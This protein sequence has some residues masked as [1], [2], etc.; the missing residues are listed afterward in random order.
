[1][2]A[3]LKK[4]K[5]WFLVSFVLTAIMIIYPGVL[6]NQ[7]TSNKIFNSINDI[8]HNNVGLLLG[9]GKYLISGINPY[10][11]NRIDATIKLFMAKKIDFVLISGDNSRKSYDEPTM[12]KN[13]LINAGIPESKIYLDYAGFRT[14]D[15]VIRAKEVFGQ[16]SLT[17]ISQ[18]FHNERAIYISLKKGIASIGYNAKDV[19]MKT[20]FKTKIREL[21]ARDKMILDLIVN[22]K[23]KFLGDKIKI[24]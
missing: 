16:D 15:S 1:M 13:D 21:L 24:K 5:Y 2:R 23:P 18:K 7:K 11:Q 9:T 4:K 3:F 20:G 22:K 10:Y 12:M 6:I 17:I 14:F 8:P 19:S